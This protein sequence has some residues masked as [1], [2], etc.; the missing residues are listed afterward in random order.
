MRSAQVGRYSPGDPST[1]G[2]MRARETVAEP[3]LK[4][5]ETTIYRDKSGSDQ[6]QIPASATINIYR[7]GATLTYSLS[8]G[9]G[10]T[11]SDVAVSATG[12]ILAGDSLQVFKSGALQSGALTVVSVDAP[13]SLTLH[14]GSG[15]TI[16]ASAGDRLVL[17]NNRPVF[18]SDP[19]GIS[20]LGSS[21]STDGTGR[22]G[23]FVR[24]KRS[25]YTATGTGFTGRMFPDAE[26]AFVSSLTGWLNALEYSSIQAAVDAL[27]AGGGTVFIPAGTSAQSACIVLPTD[28]PVR[29][30]GEGKATTILSWATNP[31]TTTNDALIRVRGD[32]TIIE[33]LGIVGPATTPTSSNPGRGISVGRKASETTGAPLRGFQLRDCAISQTPSYA[34]YAYGSDSS[35]DPGVDG[36]SFSILCGV[37]N[38][39]LSY[40]VQD[41]LVRI[42]RDC[43]TWTIAQCNIGASKGYQLYL[44]RCSLVRC[45]R[46][47]FD[48]ALDD[49]EYVLIN[50]AA[51]VTFD[52]C[53][54]EN[55]NSDSSSAYFVRITGTNA[56]SI[57]FL[58]S[59]FY[60]TNP[61]LQDDP[62]V[63]VPDMAS[64]LIACTGTNVVRGL[65]VI[66]ARLYLHVG[67]GSGNEATATGD[68]AVDDLTSEVYIAG[69]VR[70]DDNRYS[71]LRAALGNLRS[72]VIGR[73]RIRLPR[74]TS[75]NSSDPADIT[76]M[77]DL[78]DG[79][80]M[81]NA[82]AQ[83]LQV[84]YSSAWHDVLV[85]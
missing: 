70:G 71:T 83:T 67:G 6:A 9:N 59:S 27:P 36:D 3:F 13:T 57:L 32:G 54:F 23:A 74:M 73:D 68:I 26:G 5:F 8:V 12:E 38:C 84:Y 66:G 55:P 22:A 16:S 33:N 14:N 20:S 7:Q 58:N 76:N 72:I 51:T 25:D 15:S 63:A 64:N 82:T 37:N 65:I 42:N 48:T 49:S 80:I 11:V 44:D 50:D 85:N 78:V 2:Q 4:R 75:G 60:R 79:D 28:R 1:T 21:I 43:T 17:T 24:I 45:D 77:A 53:D 39:D 30:V 18:Y 35:V 61:S 41:G 34:L 81:F 69:S 19:L 52:T 62:P 31:T 46:T 47:A 10:V 29:L 40:N 56:S